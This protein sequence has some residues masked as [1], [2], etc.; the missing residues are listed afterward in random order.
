MTY[1]P[2]PP[3]RP[4]ETDAAHRA[5][6]A[7][8]TRWLAQEPRVDHWYTSDTEVAEYRAWADSTH[9]HNTLIERL[10]QGQ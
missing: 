5:R 6:V 1:P 8:W 4:K 9:W 3:K 2:P 7:R 10:T